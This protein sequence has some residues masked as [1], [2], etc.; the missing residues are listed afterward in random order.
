[1]DGG[2]KAAGGGGLAAWLGQIPA[3][4]SRNERRKVSAA[5]VNGLSGAIFIVGA[6]QPLFGA[7]GYVVDWSRMLLAVV[8]AFALHVIALR[9]VHGIED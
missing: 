3:R 7:P 8:A 2:E 5:L 6:V 9:A 1:M 4:A